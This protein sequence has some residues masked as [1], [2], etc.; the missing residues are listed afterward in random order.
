MAEAAKLSMDKRPE[1]THVS[2]L[3]PSVMPHVIHHAGE[4]AQAG[5]DVVREHEDAE[6]LGREEQRSKP[7]SQSLAPLPVARLECSGETLAHRT[8]HLT[9]LSNSPA[10]AS[11]VAG[12][13]GMRHHA[14]LIFVFL[15]ETGFH[16]VGQD[17][18]DL[19]T[20]LK[21][22]DTTAALISW[23]Q[24]IVPPQPGT[25]GMHHHIWLIFKFFCRDGVS[26]YCPGWPQ[27]PSVKQSSCLSLPKCWDYICLTLLPRLECSGV[28]MAHCSLN[29]P[30]SRD[31]PT[32]ASQV[33]Q[34]GPKHLGLSNRY[35]LAFQSAGII[36]MSHCAQPSTPLIGQIKLFHSGR[37][38]QADHLR[39]G[40]RDQPGQHGETPSLLKI[41]NEPGK[42]RLTYTHLGSF[43]NRLCCP[44]MGG[45][46]LQ[47][48][49]Q[50]A[51]LQLLLTL[52][53]LLLLT[54]LCL[55]LSLRL[56]CSGMISAHYN[57]HLL[58]SKTGFYHVVQA[59]LELLTS[60]NLPASAF[61]SAGFTDSKNEIISHLPIATKRNPANEVMWYE[62]NAPA[63]P[64]VSCLQPL[65]HCAQ[66][67]SLSKSYQTNA[68][69]KMTGEAAASV[70]LKTLAP[71]LKHGRHVAPGLVGNGPLKQKLGWSVRDIQR[72]RPFRPRV[73]LTLS[74]R[75]ECSGTILAH[76]N[77]CLSSS[78]GSCASASQ[79]AGIIG[80]HHHSWLIFVFLVEI[81]FRHVGQVG[82]KLLTSNR[83]FLSL[84]LQCSGAISAH[85][86]LCLLGLTDS[87]A[88]ASPVA[89]I[90]DA[91]HYAWLI[92]LFLL[93]TGFHHVCQA[94]LELPSS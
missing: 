59:G 49:R 4:Q 68:A 27:I 61:R 83:V 80:T 11:R 66:R 37:L 57:L 63:A 67:V 55:P 84:R 75:L 39:S 91:R 2:G 1:S 28:I 15:V 36:G 85:C 89:G 18:F 32:S 53:A 48:C 20:S 82:L 65:V 76:C 92:F 7:C 43:C 31:P 42:P 12:T 64:G 17:G 78:S 30:G 81:G 14:Q 69:E 45:H 79:V 33:A 10:S 73:S 93:E 38:R 77:L 70:H 23:T 72:R 22:S 34:A 94:G 40:I 6:G 54:A 87:S 46:K 62:G 47:G 74:P 19:L 16:H 52:I 3:V 86:N 41:Q 25:T 90:T 51:V 24:A 58:G 35:A 21:C 56:E 9:G 50:D 71:Q 5:R 26:P 44:P 88:S 13:T 29:L 60:S 8:L